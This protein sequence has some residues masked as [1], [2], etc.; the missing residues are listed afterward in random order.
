MACYNEFDGVINRNV[1]GELAAEIVR[2]E[3]R[4][5]SCTGEKS[6]QKVDIGMTTVRKFSQY[7]TW[8]NRNF[9]VNNLRLKQENVKGKN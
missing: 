2:Y 9:R 3:V 8:F 1:S 5:R 6:V 7:S 4:K